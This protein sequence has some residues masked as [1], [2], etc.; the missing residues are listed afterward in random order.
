MGPGAISQTKS[1]SGAA[2][3]PRQTI[4]GDLQIR[5]W[6]A[7]RYP[8]IPP[9]QASRCAR[10]RK[11]RLGLP[12][13]GCGPID[14]GASAPTGA[15]CGEKQFA[16][17]DTWRLIA[18]VAGRVDAAETRGPGPESPGR[19]RPQRLSCSTLSAPRSDFPRRS[20]EP[21]DPRTSDRF[22]G[23]EDEPSWPPTSGVAWNLPGTEKPEMGT[24]ARARLGPSRN[25]LR[26]PLAIR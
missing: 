5:T 11:A 4:V 3:R 18:G 17:V 1:T 14:E 8:C 23:S 10:V 2:A 15:I 22:P 20:L 21:G 7:S 13:A 9:P 12:A 19:V 24:W 26:P 25:V 6:V 16:A